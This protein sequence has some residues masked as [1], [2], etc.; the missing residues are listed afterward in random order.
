MPSFSDRRG[1]PSCR[2]EES[3][4]RR[5]R[6][7][8]RGN[9][10]TCRARSKGWIEN[11]AAR[12]PIWGDVDL[13]AFCVVTGYSREHATR[14]LSKLRRECGLAFETKLRKKGGATTARWGV[15]VA[16]PDKLLFDRHSL[17]YDRRGN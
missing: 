12:S 9:V 7:R 15:M 5:C 6:G 10:A 1:L 16:D 8:R 14:E 3:C 2:K 11:V 17:F 4:V 13:K